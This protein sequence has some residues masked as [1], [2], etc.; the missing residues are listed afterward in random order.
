MA[1]KP[2]IA[3]R[4]EDMEKELREIKSNVTHASPPLSTRNWSTSQ[5]GSDHSPAEPLPIISVPQSVTDNIYAVPDNGSYFAASE[6]E[7]QRIG[8]LELSP[9]AIADILNCYFTSYH[10]LFPILPDPSVFVLN[11]QRCSRLL[12]WVLIAI[13]SKSMAKY[14]QLHLQLEP[15]VRTLA[16]SI[17]Q[18]TDHPLGTVQALL[19]LCWWPFPFKALRDDPSWMYAG[20]VVHIALRSGL[21]RPYH[22]SDFVYGDRLDATGVLTFGKAWIGCFI[23]NQIIASE[24]GLP[25]T[26]PLDSTILSVVRG[27]SEVAFPTVLVQQLRIAYQSFNICNTL[28]NNDMSASG[29]L[30]GNT[31]MIKVFERGIQEVETQIGAQ[32]ST[33]TEMALL[34]VKLQLYSFAFTTDTQHIRIDSRASG[35][36]SKAGRDATRVITV[37]SQYAPSHELLQ[38]WPAT[39]RSSIVYAVHV[40]LRLLAYPEH[41]DQD[42]AK[43][44][45]GQAWMLLRSRSELEN[46]SWARLCDIIS[47]LSRT[48][49]TGGPP[50][51]AAVQARMSAN[52]VVQSIWQARGRFSDDVLRQRPKDYTAAEARRDLTQFGLDLL[53][54]TDFLDSA[55]FDA[56]SNSILNPDEG[57]LG[58]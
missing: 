16:T 25:C 7:M 6:F 13:A 44:Y 37:A 33:Y 56:I 23:V 3:T 53:V 41:L 32:M 47:Y 52:I 5:H 30:A 48:D 50:V 18:A 39:A 11:Y 58:A 12:F 28:G 46:D 42:T 31:D 14:N 9:V 10:H 36:L 4:A 38:P 54:G 22:F 8:H 29:L 19:L 2:R 34:R 57:G 20:S 49:S 27:T 45:I 35:Y 55:Q 51:M 21:H 17:E 43:N 15:H 1:S 26:V 24:L 40:L